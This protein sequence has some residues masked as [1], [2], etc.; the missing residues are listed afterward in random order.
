MGFRRENLNPDAEA[1]PLAGFLGREDSR[2]DAVVD[3]EV[4]KTLL[5]KLGERDKRIL[6]MRFFRGM[7]QS[8]IGEQLQVSQLQV[9]RL[10]TRVLEELRVGF[11]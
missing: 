2:F 11:G 6:V 3:R 8:E 5:A 7:T 9:S 10:L 1:A 4:L